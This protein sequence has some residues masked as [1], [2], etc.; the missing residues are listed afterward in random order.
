MITMRYFEPS[1]G[2]KSTQFISVDWELQDR[3]DFGGV[4]PTHL[5]YLYHIFYRI[6]IDQSTSLVIT[7]TIDFEHSYPPAESRPDGLLTL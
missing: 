5:V 3:N 4:V 6:H 7:T 2:H 1:K